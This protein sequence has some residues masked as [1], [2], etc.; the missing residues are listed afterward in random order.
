MKSFSV[1]RFAVLSVA[2]LTFRPDSA[3]AQGLIR[4]D[5]SVDWTR[6]HN[7]A[8]TTRLLRE[9]V[10]R[11]P[12]LARMYTHRQELQ[13]QG[14]LDA[15][16]DQHP[17]QAGGRQAGLLH[18]WRRSLL[19]AG[20]FRAGALPGL[21]LRHPARQGP[22][23][24]AP[25]RHPYP[26]PAP[27]VQSRRRRLL[28][29]P[30][31]RPAQHRAALGRRRRRTVSTRTRPRTSTAMGRSPRCGSPARKGT[32][33]VV[34]RRSTP[35]GGPQGGRDGRH[36]LPGLLGGDRQRRRRRV[37]RGRR[38]RHRHE[39]EFPAHLGPALPAVRGGAFSPLRAGDAG[40]PGLHRVPPQH[41][42][43]RPQP[44]RRRLHVPAALDQPARRP[45]GRRPGAGQ[46]V[47][48]PLHR[49]HRPPRCRTATR[50][51]GAAGTAP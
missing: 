5:G 22:A 43:H 11:H 31:R 45:R 35:D 21:V 13:G 15:R 40:H 14:P 10:A 7:S 47:R 9:L 1:A 23:G 32:E 30:S 16:A 37:Q 50:A 42:R 46:A 19:R 29:D 49:R 38:G 17:G 39:P 25:A 28:P 44:H 48:R 20:R 24:H 3:A 8:E 6:Y 33:K 12:R 2:L 26:V 27:Q 18:R 34:P 4:P 41:H 51:K 36:L